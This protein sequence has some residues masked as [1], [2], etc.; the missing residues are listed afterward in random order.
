MGQGRSAA[1]QIPPGMK[2]VEGRYH[3]LIYDIP[4]DQAQEALI[5]MEAMVD[6][7][8][9]RTRDFSGKL[10]RKL[11]FYLF[12]DRAQY[13]AN[14]GLPGSVG[15][16]NGSKLM[17]IAGDKLTT[18][19]WHTIQHE[20]FHQFAFAVIGG[21]LPIWA[22]EGLAEYFG[23]AIF[24]GDGFVSG[25]I[26][27]HRLRRVAGLMNDAK[28]KP[29]QEML[30]MTNAQWNR[31]L[32]HTNY[33]QVWAMTMFLAHG[34]DGKYQ[35][36]FGR[37]M[38]ALSRGAPWD[39]A[40]V[41]SFGNV[42]AFE[43]KWI[44]WW[45]DEKREAST[46]V[47]AQAATQMLTSYLARGMSQKQTFADL[48]AL[49]AAIEKNEVQ[50]NKG[51]ILPESLA[52]DCVSLTRGLIKSEVVFTLE[53]GATARDQP[54]VVCVLPDGT[55]ITGTYKLKGSRVASVASKID[56]PA[57]EAKK[58]DEKQKK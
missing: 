50:S 30:T 7:Y 8:T 39:R 32:N 54:S 14:G 20:G 11:P 12:R 15:I 38:I 1:P 3:F 34:D 40:W 43:K 56:P 52:A 41:D 24:T 49:L 10:N 4:D 44:E 53:A 26:P 2:G 58:D 21:N 35:K 16:F 45:T 31:E 9:L 19:T 36:A 55:K 18:R 29:V 47:F 28:F 51:D 46:D 37:Y 22:N 27:K 23:E 5:R 48:D 42:E 17:A 6:E 13:T 33:D 57:K 25:A